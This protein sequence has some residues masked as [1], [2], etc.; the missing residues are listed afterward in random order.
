MAKKWYVVIAGK[1]VGVFDSW[2]DASP[3]VI[4]VSGNQHCSFTNEDEARNAF[5]RA[6]ASGNVKIIGGGQPLAAA[7]SLPQIPSPNRAPTNRS[8]GRTQSTPSAGSSSRSS[9]LSSPETNVTYIISGPRNRDNIS[10]T[11]TAQ[12]S[13]V[14][15]HISSPT[16][17]VTQYVG[18]P[19]R[20][21]S[22]QRRG[23]ATPSSP[24]TGITHYSYTSSPV[25]SVNM[26]RGSSSSSDRS[27]R[28]AA[29][30]A[31]PSQRSLS[32]IGQPSTARRLPTYFISSDTES[33]DENQVEEPPRRSPLLSPLT[34]PHLRSS[35]GP[36]NQARSPLQHRSMTS[37]PRTG[38][39]GDKSV[40]QSPNP[41]G[42]GLSN[43]DPRSPMRRVPNSGVTSGH[44]CPRPSPLEH[45]LIQLA[46][47]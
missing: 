27:R 46:L 9:H 12:R 19:S 10:P 23:A 17:G 41:V 36:S 40:L 45:S 30:V 47:G 21:H 26:D 33:E 29:T 7:V 2:T 3:N 38:N 32:S 24:E 14:S 43:V 34:S 22:S 6:R 44:L 16:T 1:K 11:P 31:T 25:T 37:S 28:R 15:S 8:L 13:S 18:S 20:P 39:K 4:G 5:E 35:P 42:L